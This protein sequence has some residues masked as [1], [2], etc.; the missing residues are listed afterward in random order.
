MQELFL[1]IWI[2]VIGDLVD[3]VYHFALHGFVVSDGDDAVLGSR[4]G[5]GWIPGEGGEGRE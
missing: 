4:D 2:I 1:R 3:Y 5:E